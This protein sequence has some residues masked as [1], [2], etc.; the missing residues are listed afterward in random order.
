MA[1]NLKKLDL[2]LLVIFESVYSTQNISRAATRLAMSQPAV[3]NA[4]R[5]CA[6][7][8]TIRCSC[9]RRA[10]SSRPCERVN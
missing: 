8:S 9:A 4:W 2:N 3:S 7:S 1:V 5:A 6:R 10:A